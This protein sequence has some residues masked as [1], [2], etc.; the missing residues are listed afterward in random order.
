MRR[1]F[2]IIFVFLLLWTAA[3]NK[4]RAQAHPTR[5]RFQNYGFHKVNLSSFDFFQMLFD[6]Y[7]T[8]S[9]EVPI[10]PKLTVLIHIQY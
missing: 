3:H 2:N 5:R 7:A 6:S 8:R 1:C 9:S 10:L 4:T